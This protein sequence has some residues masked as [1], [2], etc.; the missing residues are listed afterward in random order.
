MY[1]YNE[2]YRR[3]EV[4]PF[5]SGNKTSTEIIADAGTL[6]R[7]GCPLYLYA[8]AGFGMRKVQWETIDHQWIQ[9]TPASLMGFSGDIGLMGCIKG[10]TISAGVNTINFKYMEIEAGIGW[11]F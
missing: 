9:Y 8:G 7:L 6:V 5:Y 10:F 3:E 1:V 2:E 4:T 11:M